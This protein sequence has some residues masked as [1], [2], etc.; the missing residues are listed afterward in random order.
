L[1]L[2]FSDLS[3]GE[4]RRIA[5]ASQGFGHP[6]PARPGPRHIRETI[7]TLGLLQI[8]CVNVV[9]QA[10]HQ[11]VYS[12][13]GP[14][15]R[16]TFDDVA[17]RSG[18]FTEQWAHEA[19]IIP[20]ST[21]PLLRHRMGAS[22]I[23]PWGFE[24]LML[25]HPEYTLWVLEQ[26]KERGPIGAE[27]LP[28]PD[29]VDRRIAGAWVG[30]VPRA[31][32][33]AHFMR[34][35][36][37]VVERRSDFS[38]VFDVA[39]RR[40]PAEHYGRRVEPDEADRELLRIAARAH[41]IAAAKDLADYFRMKVGEVR[42]RIAELVE[43]GELT[44]VAVEGWRETAYLHRDAA[45]PA[46]IDAAALLS[47]FDPVIWT[48][49][50]AKRLFD[51]DYRVEIFV[52]PPQRRW[53]FYVLPFLLGDRLVARVDLKADRAARRLNV[54]GA[55]AEAGAHSADVA[56][57]LAAELRTLAHWIGME[58]VA[59]G[60]RGNLARALAAAA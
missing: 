44:E 51:F 4:A 5:L 14:Y 19:S 24:R 3:I 39:E 58:T 18:E 46:R 47:P 48:R 8:D 20:V 31:M 33:E 42:P 17:Y 60:R 7:R 38:R 40:I 59:V 55:W 25:A 34:G 49:P 57:P 43:A 22:R 16:A 23:R 12:R 27:A 15:D 45:V 21:W 54:R 41:G 26:V 53:G 28:A 1:R 35:E 30:T 6:R 52:P 32:L 37:A 9:A 36:L 10:H 13:L 50:R 56:G 11:V 29:G 2:N